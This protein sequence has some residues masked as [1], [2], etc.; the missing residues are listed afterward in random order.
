MWNVW[1]RWLFNM[2]A[3]LSNHSEA[4][5]SPLLCLIQEEEMH[6]SILELMGIDLSPS[7]LFGFAPLV[8]LH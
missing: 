2:L 1:L 4:I 6:T 7:N 5:D 8:Q 3:F